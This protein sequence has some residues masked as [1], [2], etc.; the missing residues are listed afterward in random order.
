[1]GIFSTIK[2]QGENAQE[3]IPTEKAIAPTVPKTKGLFTSIGS[4]TPSTKSGGLFSSIKPASTTPET[5][6]FAA[7]DQ[8]GSYG[9]SDAE[10]DTSG[11]PFF[12]YRN[13][14]DEATT[15]DKTR[16]AV[17]FD[18]RVPSA[19]TR[20]SFYNPRAVGLRAELKDTLG[21]AYSDELDHK[22]ALALSGSNDPKNLRA[23]PATKND[24][25]SIISQ[26]Q[27][28]VISGKK[29]LFDAQVE[30]AKQK[31]IEIPF[32]GKPKEKGF[33]E[34]VTDKV[35]SYFSPEAETPPREKKNYTPQEQLAQADKNK[36]TIS[37]P[38]ATAQSVNLIDKKGNFVEKIQINSPDEYENAKKRASSIGG[39]IE[40]STFQGKNLPFSESVI[41]GAKK[42]Y[43]AVKETIN[44]EAQRIQDL[45]TT[46]S[47]N[48]VTEDGD[49][50]RSEPH[51]TAEALTAFGKAG[52]GLINVAFSPFT[53]VFTG[54]ENI[55]VAGKVAEGFNYIL[56]KAGDMESVT[57]NKLLDVLPIDEKT[58]ETI[59]PLV[60]ELAQLTGMI[61]VGKAGHDTIIKTEKIRSQIKE[62][63]STQISKAKAQ[64][65]A[66]PNKTGGFINLNPEKSPQKKYTQGAQ[67][68]A[69]I[70]DTSKDQQPVDTEGKFV[71]GSFGKNA[72]ARKSEIKGDRFPTSELKS[73]LENT[74]EVL[75]ASSDSSNWR[76]DNAVHIAKMPDG[77]MRAVYTRENKA[78]QEEIIN[79]H[80]INPEKGGEKYIEDL[81]KNGVLGRDRT[82]NRLVR[83]EEPYPF[84]HEDIPKLTP[85]VKEVKPTFEGHEDLTTKTVDTYLKGKTEVSYQYIS[86]LLNKDEIKKPEKAILRAVLDQYPEGS[87]IPVKEFADKVKTELLPLTHSNTRNAYEYVNLPKEIRGNVASYEEHIWNS[88][89]KTSAGSVHFGAE[90]NYFAHTRI[91]DLS[92][93]PAGSTSKYTGVSKTR[94]I[95]ELQSDLMQKGR[96][97]GEKFAEGQVTRGEAE[98]A[99]E[100]GQEVYELNDF[101]DEVSVGEKINSLKDLEKSEA[102][103]FVVKGQRPELAKLEPYRN[104]WA[105]RI[106]KEE[107]KLAGIKGKT[108]LQFPTGETAM[109]IEG[110]GENA[111][112]FFPLEEGYRLERGEKIPNKIIS[113][114]KLE[115]VK[116]QVGKEVFFGEP[117]NSE[118][119]IT[120][121]NKKDIWI[122][123]DVLGDGKFKAVPKEVFDNQFER[124]GLNHTNMEEAISY[125]EHHYPDILNRHAESF[126]ISGKV[127]TNNP[128]YKFYESDIGKYL[129]NNYDAKKITDPQGVTWW[130][131]SVPEEAGKAPVT[132]FKR[133]TLISR[134]EGKKILLE[135]A[136]KIVEQE[137]PNK[138]IRL[139]FTDELI[140]GIA[141]GRFTD[142]K[143]AF[144]GIL[145]PLIELY[146]EG[147]FTSARTTYHEIGHYIFE[148]VLSPIE[149]IRFKE[150]ALREM[151]PLRKKLYKKAGYSDADI[152]LEYLIDEYA[153]AKYAEY[154]GKKYN[155]PHS[156][157]IGRVDKFLKTIVDT[158][159]KVKERVQE[160]VKEHGTKGGFVNF[161]A[162]AEP[163]PK[164]NSGE[165]K[166]PKIEEP[167]PEEMGI[168]VSHKEI[169]EGAKAL[170]KSRAKEAKSAQIETIK[171]NTD[172]DLKKVELSILEESLSNNPARGLVKFANKRTGE[173]PEVL[174]QGKGRFRTK[175][176][177]IADE[178]GFSTSE[179]AREAYQKYVRQQKQITDL[180]EEIKEMSQEHG[181]TVKENLSE[182]VLSEFLKKE[183]KTTEQL[184]AFETTRRARI[185]SKAQA[186]EA[187]KK[188]DIFSQS[189]DPKL[190]DQL[191]DLFVYRNLLRTEVQLDPARSLKKF[192][193]DKK[194][195]KIDEK[196]LARIG[197]IDMAE[198]KSAYEAYL[199]RASE[200]EIVGHRL[201]EKTP[202]IQDKQVEQMKILAENAPVL[203]DISNFEKGAKDVFRIF[204]K[205][206]GKDI[207]K[208]D[209]LII[210]PFNKGKKAFIDDQ[211]SLINEMKKE[212]VEKLR[213]KKGS[214]ESK[215]VQNLGEKNIE[216]EEVVRK[217][218]KYR[219]N[220]IKTAT[221]WFRNKYDTLLDQ[222]NEVRKEIYP[223]DPSKI[224]PKRD[225]YFRHFHELA[226]GLEALKNIFETP[227]A[228]SPGL[229]GISDF[230]QPKSKFLSFA[231][232]RLG[233]LTKEDAVGG[234]LNYIQA[235][236]YAKNIDPHIGAFRK[237]SKQL[238]LATEK[239]RNLN[240]FIEFL[241]DF[242]NDL[243]GKTNPLDRAFQKYIPGG[244]KTMKALNWLNGR[245]KAN[246]ILGNV[247]SSLSQIFN[248]PQ[249]I[250]SAKQYSIKG[251]L[252]S[253]GQ[254]FGSNV[255]MSKSAFIK[256]RYFGRHFQQ[257]AEGL[258][259]K[260]KAFATWMTG[261][262]DEVGTKFIWN[263]HYEKAV[264][265]G[266]KDPIKYADATTRDLVAG[267][268]VGEVPLIQK[269]KVFQLVAPFQ[270]EVQNMWYVL[271]D[272]VKRR[273]FTGLVILFATGYLMNQVSREVKGSDVTFDPVNSTIEGIRSARQESN[274][275]KALLK[276]SGR[277]LGEILSN[278]PFGQS[279]ASIFPQNGFSIKGYS[280]TRNE[281]FGE[282][283]PTRYGGGIL[284]LEGLQKPLTRVLLPFGG[285][286]AE[287]TYEGV[288]ALI[289][290]KVEKSDG[291]TL[292]PVKK[293]TK[294][295]IK[296]PI[297]GPGSTEEAREH[298]TKSR[299]QEIIDMYTKNQT[300]K[301][302][303]KTQEAEQIYF[304]L[305]P[306]DKKI[307]DSVKKTDTKY[308]L[309]TK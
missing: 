72:F 105:P 32:T 225:D 102:T 277:E 254:V 51:T 63:I 80:Q 128:I 256:E 182:I 131:F 218:G 60:S 140:E 166:K 46:L 137:I 241:N 40:K 5:P 244:R 309:Y 143:D 89:I 172:L 55:P 298:Y 303:G 74:Q 47:E 181:A 175:G 13:P 229:A 37:S 23:E 274:L 24:D 252:R 199:S 66:T 250:A 115:P 207:E 3:T 6:Y 235:H 308:H 35:K 68:T 94:R 209:A 219:A 1:M 190:F 193:K 259:K 223:N 96:L 39:T 41:H 135:D 108:K 294:N 230:T 154:L 233:L 134:L 204:K 126:D 251:A 265:E 292:Y 146:T 22:I 130:E 301:K 269:S 98:K 160:I 42:G 203:R 270:L 93:L 231:Q 18:P 275:G 84:G 216:Y 247:S 43:S 192:A 77:E 158:F 12:A 4:A 276:F 79:W 260:P 97:E 159:E 212:I 257:F 271:G 100:N 103:D 162:E 243:A 281:F 152:P 169:V 16:T 106:I 95:L 21:I 109:K 73:T 280:L 147:K 222:V 8:G 258:L 138:K 198:A 239:D 267:R 71:L 27:Q 33:L 165:K 26:L 157:F 15:T 183:T 245:V 151:G 170:E 9:F 53:G 61:A 121:S 52:L 253:F 263:S 208:A 305:S 195:R 118:R 300:L 83:T 110:L 20:D 284:S 215:Y 177:D 189:M 31:G 127:D 119:R 29:S 236:S 36:G 286:Q 272:T 184:V 197:Y 99:L 205:V 248:V 78:G 179:G 85:P 81:R 174:G 283:D 150:R 25:S 173:L 38:E 120:Q 59:R 117:G 268:G 112:R 187:F 206:F 58:K 176:D 293:T 246:T 141:S 75:R 164:R 107:V 188:Y 124:R 167:S 64:Y 196:T 91:E 217:Y 54:A 194:L 125:G 145:K 178:L 142:V 88:P 34:K 295:I 255:P 213:I 224:I 19:Q 266:I 111:N 48:K 56:G 287:K 296:A 156:G 278:I 221:E 87:K 144:R 139:E 288:K 302:Q 185:K 262:L 132:A 116:L 234:F 113:R 136:R 153:K 291:K 307:Y 297:F 290:G 171:T 299:R 168:R 62:K 232:K 210:E 57:A 214:T 149:K 122:I 92:D 200:L 226:Y 133:K 289:K 90:P 264:S 82:S 261:V 76:H 249:G 186:D 191:K 242:S 202:V 240:N 237:L 17:K 114:E 30:L 10:K 129:R 273:D 104:E 50:R 238:A 285:A 11:R 228:I 306:A 163:T 65:E 86:D 69:D 101:M 45:I 67:K 14:G 7:V 28:D 161:G 148:Y 49:V 304:N 155:G 180:R 70:F 279:L 220:E 282:G 227:S 2:P 211:E 123:T 44:D 201:S